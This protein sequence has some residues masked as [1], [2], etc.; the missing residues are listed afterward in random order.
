MKAIIILL[1]QIAL[2]LCLAILEW[3]VK[4]LDPEFRIEIYGLGDD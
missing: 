1:A 4:K 3:A 2:I